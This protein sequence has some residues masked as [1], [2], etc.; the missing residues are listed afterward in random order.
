MVV[1]FSR[2]FPQIHRSRCPDY[3]FSY[4]NELLVC[5]G[6]SADAGE[7]VSAEEKDAGEGVSA[8]ANGLILSA[9]EGVSAG[10]V[11]R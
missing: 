2:L 11:A 7:G 5:E 9:G 6:V 3:L 10:D 1:S 4:L 8:D